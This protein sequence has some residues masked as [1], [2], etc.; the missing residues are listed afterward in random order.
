MDLLGGSRV[1]GVCRRAGNAM[2]SAAR[3]SFL[4]RK[5]NIPLNVEGARLAQSRGKCSAFCV[6]AL[7]GSTIGGWL[8]QYW[9]RL[10]GGSIKGISLLFGNFF[11]LSAINF[12]LAGRFGMAACAAAAF[13]IALALFWAKGTPADW[14]ESSLPGRIALRKGYSLPR[15]NPARS[16]TVYLA[17]CGIVGGVAAWK[18][19]LVMGGAIT[20][21]LAAAPGIFALPP[22]WTLCLLC[23]ILP[24]APTTVCWAMSL[25]IVVS[26][27]FGRAFRRM[28][29]VQWDWTDLL[30]LLFPILCVIST[31]FSFQRGNSLTVLVMWMGLFICVFAVKRILRAKKD[32]FAVLGSLTAGATLS[33]FIGIWQFLFG[34]A[35]ITWTDANLFSD[36]ELRV[37]STFE[38]PNVYGE[39]LLLMIPLVTAMVLYVRKPLW[40]WSLL[41]V[42]GLLL[43]NLLVTYS[44]GCYVGIAL[45]ALI[46]LWHF[47]KKWLV[48][49]LMVGLPVG[50]AVMPATV[51]KRLMS[52]FDQRDSSTSYRMMIYIGTLAMLSDYFFG[53]VGMGEEAF[54][55]VYPLYALSGVTAPHPHSL[56]FQITVAFGVMGLV[57]ILI[58]MGAF[59]WEM[60]RHTLKMERRD[61]LLMLGF[62][63][64]ITGFALQSVFDYTWYNYRVF[65]L[66][67][68]VLA[69]GFGAV[70]FLKGDKENA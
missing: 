3:K 22:L 29:A 51:M 21:G 54:N 63:S 66:F 24:L 14:L 41:A 17:L 61:R 8:Y 4:F 45:T 55:S 10:L 42:D 68:I 64:L 6:Q 19:G 60:N 23:F 67:W 35:D 28:E 9:G 44:R 65:Q 38:N 31:V 70:R 62:G 32:L 26:Y 5:R 48:A 69:L 39:F 57:Y 16:V 36:V 46:F 56:F 34:E 47:S 2:G 20:V 52:I 11:L 33:G 59:H 30:L 25:M 27:F 40:R 53:G 37:Y 49:I 43:V 7:A 12:A 1:L 18:F 50:L 15:A 13:L 58:L